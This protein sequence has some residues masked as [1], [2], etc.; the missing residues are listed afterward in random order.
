[1]ALVLLRDDLKV[2]QCQ[3][4]IEDDLKDGIRRYQD[5]AEAR[6]A[7]CQLVPQQYHRDAARQANQDHTVAVG[8][9]VWQCGPCQPYSM[10]DSLFIPNGDDL[11]LSAE[12][13]DNKPCSKGFFVDLDLRR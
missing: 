9:Q 12:T 7:A 8:G 4:C 13:K 2:E 3:G 1:M 6:V 10:A 11:Q 5:G